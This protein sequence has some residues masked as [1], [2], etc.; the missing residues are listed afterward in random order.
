M[1]ELRHLEPGSPSQPDPSCGSHCRC[2][3]KDAEVVSQLKDE[4]MCQKLDESRK[5][6]ISRMLTTAAPWIVING[7]GGLARRRC[8]LDGALGEQPRD[9]REDQNGS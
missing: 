2:R 1:V 4:K 8:R 7:G 6:R 3:T 5:L 9:L